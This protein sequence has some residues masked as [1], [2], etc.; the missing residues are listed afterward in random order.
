MKFYC[1]C[2]ALLGLIA[3]YDRPSARAA[4]NPLETFLTPQYHLCMEKV[5]SGEGVERFCYLDE[6]E[7]WDIM[8]TDRYN[9]Y[10]SYLTAEERKKFKEIQ[11]NWWRAREGSAEWAATVPEIG[12]MYR[13]FALWRSMVETALRA[14]WMWTR[15]NQM[16]WTPERHKNLPLIENLPKTQCGE[17]VMGSSVVVGVVSET[18]NNDLLVLIDKNPKPRA[19]LDLDA[20]G[21]KLLTEAGA[22]AGF[23]VDVK[24]DFVR[25]W[26]VLEN[27]CHWH[28]PVRRVTVL[29]K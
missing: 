5:K 11:L 21:H 9:D 16:Q 27:T 14:D 10:M 15:L 28:K 2:F 18:D 17:K 19:E 7:R 22:K 12:S 20:Q 6:Q 8:L 4:E 24:Y 1:C 25:K 3:V 13:D 23:T 26:D 29:K